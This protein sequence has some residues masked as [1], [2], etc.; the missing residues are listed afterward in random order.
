MQLTI[1][2]LRDALKVVDPDKLIFFDFG[3]CYPDI[4][5]EGILS[6][7]RGF[8]ADIAIPYRSASEFYF[9]NQVNPTITAGDLLAKIERTIG[10]PLYGYKGGEFLATEAKSMW[11]D[12]SGQFSSTAIIGVDEDYMGV[13]LRTWHMMSRDM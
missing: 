8:F 11:A 6:S 13:I 4:R 5:K 2:E 7:Y 1:G 10:V 3:D 9:V 12:N